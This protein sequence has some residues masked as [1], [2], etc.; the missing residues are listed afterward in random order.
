MSKLRTPTQM[1]TDFPRPSKWPGL[2]HIHNS[3]HYSVVNGTTSREQ[4]ADN[5]VL[6]FIHDTQR[7]WP[8]IAFTAI[9]I[10]RIYAKLWVQI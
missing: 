1:I 7:T 2:E 3:R 5:N 8:E 4:S 10:L 9:N 6:C